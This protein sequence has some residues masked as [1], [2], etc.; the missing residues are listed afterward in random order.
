MALHRKV[1][2]HMSAAEAE[3]N[4]RKYQRERE[5]NRRRALNFVNTV[6]KCAEKLLD[7]HIYAGHKS[8]RIT[9]AE[10]KDGF[11]RSFFRRLGKKYDVEHI[12]LVFRF[13]GKELL[14]IMESKYLSKGWHKVIVGD[15]IILLS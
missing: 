7:E 4:R 8:P 2:E 15:C 3:Y 10:I 9:C 13:A 11:H 6:A 5:E 12:I 1:A 14:E